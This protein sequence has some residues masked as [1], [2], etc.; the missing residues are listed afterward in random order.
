M[1]RFEKPTIQENLS[2]R[3]V[4]PFAMP[5]SP[6]L[7]PGLR[8][9]CGT[10]CDYLAARIRSAGLF[11]R[12]FLPFRKFLCLTCFTLPAEKPIRIK[13]CTDLV[14]QIPFLPVRKNLPI[15]P[16]KLLRS[17]RSTPPVYRFGASLFCTPIIPRFRG[18]S[19][20]FFKKIENFFNFL[21][22]TYCFGERY[23]QYHC[24]RTQA[25]VCL[26]PQKRKMRC[27]R[28]LKTFWRSTLRDSG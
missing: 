15:R 24:M 19:I 16:M 5:A 11:F 17:V 28:A 13:P 22:A 4:H 3:P 23:H 1:C 8:S 9:Q 7:R 10:L 12:F 26:L 14:A 27:L 18:L 2:A 20:P 21:F 25:V 6:A